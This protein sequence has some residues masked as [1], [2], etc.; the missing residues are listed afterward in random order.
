MGCGCG[1]KKAV[2]SVPNS[3]MSSSGNFT[4]D[5]LSQS[6]QEQTPGTQIVPIEYIGKLAET[7]SIRSRVDASVTYRFGN[8]D[9]NRTGAVFLADAEFLMGITNEFG[10]PNY[11]MIMAGNVIENRDP[12]TFLGASIE[13]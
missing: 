13:A 2:S 7:F 1:Q 6:I 11:R 9:Y 10:Q 5:S 4:K 12:V 8:N 3:T